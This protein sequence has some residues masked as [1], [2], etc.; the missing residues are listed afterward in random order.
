V[1]MKVQ[2][3]NLGTIGET[4]PVIEINFLTFIQQKATAWVASD[5]Y[6]RQQKMIVRG[7]GQYAHHPKYNLARHTTDH[8]RTYYIDPSVKR[9]DALFSTN[10]IGLINPFNNVTY[11]KKLVFLD[12]ND[13]QQLHWFKAYSTQHPKTIHLILVNGDVVSVSKQFKRRVF[14]DQHGKLSDYFQLKHVPV[15]ISEDFKQKKWRVKEI[16]ILK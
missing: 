11:H 13:H 1:M 14:F 3:K 15:I 12:A 10:E 8:P 4:Y 2:A 7:V 6:K 16:N 5:A 9:N